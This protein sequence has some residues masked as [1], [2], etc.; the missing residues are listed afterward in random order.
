ME[1]KNGE[2][3]VPYRTVSDYEKELCYAIDAGIDFFA[4]CWYPDTIGERNIW[5][6][7]SRYTFLN[8]YYPPLNYARKLYHQRQYD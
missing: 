2:Y 3:V 7:D 6:D 1:K 5:H 4:Y 8:D